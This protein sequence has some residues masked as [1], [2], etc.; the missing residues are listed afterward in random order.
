[1]ILGGSSVP[2]ALPLLFGSFK[3]YVA[4]LELAAAV[5]TIAGAVLMIRNVMSVR[6]QQRLRTE[7][8]SVPAA[9]YSNRPNQ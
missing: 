3:P 5:L 1:M 9:E 4:L 7:G 8:A 6:T 2:R